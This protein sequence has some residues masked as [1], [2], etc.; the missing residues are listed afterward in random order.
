MKKLEKSDSFIFALWEIFRESMRF[1]W[2]CIR[3]WR[4]VTPE[5]FF[6]QKKKP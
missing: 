2:M 1:A 5:E 6:S 4:C 3:E